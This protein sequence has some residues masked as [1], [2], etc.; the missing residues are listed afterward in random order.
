VSALVERWA[1]VGD[2]PG[3]RAMLRDAANRGWHLLGAP[4]EVRRDGVE[5]WLFVFDTFDPRGEA[6]PTE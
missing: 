2:D 3:T 4:T 1:A 6:T 5:G